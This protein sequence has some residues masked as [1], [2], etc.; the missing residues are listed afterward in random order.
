MLFFLK[1]N[2]AI[3]IDMKPVLSMYRKTI[4][5]SMILS[6]SNRFVRSKIENLRG[7]C[8]RGRCSL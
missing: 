5:C 1:K 6:Q 8:W 4:E 2:E 7:C 3:L